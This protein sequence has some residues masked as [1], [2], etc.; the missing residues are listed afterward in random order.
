LTVFTEQVEIPEALRRLVET[1][2]QNGGPTQSTPRAL[3][4]A[5]GARRRG[6]WINAE[7]KAMLQKL[8]VATTPDF[9]TSFIDG[10][11]EIAVSPHQEKAVDGL[12]SQPPG[13]ELLTGGS[14]SDPVWRIRM[15]GAANTPP[16]S[17]KRTVSKAVTMMLLND[18]SQLPVLSTEKQISWRS[19]GRAAALGRSCD[20]VRD[21]MEDAVTTSSETPLLEA[22]ALIAKH[23]TVLVK[24]KGKIVGLVTTSDLSL[25]FKVLAEPFLLLE[26]I[27]KHL[28]RLIDGRFTRETIEAAKNEADADRSIA[29]VADLT[30]GE[31]V[32]LLENAANWQNLCLPLDRACICAKLRAVRDIRNEV[33]HFSPDGVPPDALELLREMVKFLQHL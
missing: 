1:V 9:E 18:F 15:L 3:I 24:D 13:T 27:E 21:C 20:F 11:I 12:G 19:I 14:V 22:I 8:G 28:R 32:R 29:D 23:E 16:V 33:M 2:R 31:Y 4:E 7:I 30:F 6:R 26:E 10:E 5:Y 17:A 25:A